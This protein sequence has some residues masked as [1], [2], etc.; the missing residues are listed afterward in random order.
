MKTRSHDLSNLVCGGFFVVVGLFFAVSSTRLGV[1]TSLGMGPGYFPLLLSSALILIGIVVAG[2]ALGS[3]GERFSAMTWR[4]LLFILPAPL[5]FGMTVRGLGFIPSLFLT[6]FLAT[7]ASGTMRVSTALLL[8]TALTAFSTL[9]FSYA[10]GLPYAL[11]G[12]W[13]SR[14]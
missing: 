3:A 5:V 8:S 4:G 10:L 14:F 9:V 7:F 11:F 12:P 13:L 2:S 6:A 1:G